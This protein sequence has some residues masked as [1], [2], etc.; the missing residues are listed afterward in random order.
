MRDTLTAIFKRHYPNRIEGVDWHVITF[1]GKADL[2]KNAVSKM[3]AWSY[4][5]PHFIYLRDSDGADCRALKSRLVERLEK[6]A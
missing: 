5:D 1:E 4:N 6:A 3:R 2:E